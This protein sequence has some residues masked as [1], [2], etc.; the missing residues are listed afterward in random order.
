MIIVKTGLRAESP[1]EK[2]KTY[3][4]YSPLCKKKPIIGFRFAPTYALQIVLSGLLTQ[5]EICRTP[6]PVVNS[7]IGNT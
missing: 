4:A 6:S 2:V 7:V 5:K 1:K 3:R